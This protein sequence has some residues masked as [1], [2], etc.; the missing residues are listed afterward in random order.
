MI[1]IKLILCFFILWINAA[2]YE[3]DDREL[4]YYSQDSFIHKLGLSVAAK[5]R[6]PIKDLGHG[7]HQIITKTLNKHI[8]N[9]CIG[10]KFENIETSSNCTGFLVD[11]DLMVTAGHCINTQSE[12]ENSI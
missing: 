12:C 5:V 10:E 6:Y 8:K 1:V 7:K 2:I 9:M 11:N 4:V 3:S